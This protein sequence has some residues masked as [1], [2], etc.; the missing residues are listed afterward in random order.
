MNVSDL[1][2]PLTHLGSGSFGEISLVE[3]RKTKKEYAAKVEPNNEKSRL[4]HEY[5]IYRQLANVEGVPRVVDFLC[6]SSCHIMVMDLLGISLDVLMEKYK[7]FSHD[8]VAKLGVDMVSLMQNIHERGIIHRDIKPNNFMFDPDFTSLYIM[9]FGLSKRYVSDGKHMKLRV[10]RSLVGTARYTSLNIH[11]GFEPSRRDD[12]ESIGY[13]MV[14]FVR[15]KLPWQGIRVKNKDCKDC[16]KNACETHNRVKLIGESK[17]CISTEIL[18]HGMP[19]AFKQFIDYCRDL[20][21]DQVPDYE[22]LR[23][24]LYPHVGGDYSFFR[25]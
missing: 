8:L 11:H 13:M 23:S 24:L 25:N 5:G 22:Y 16:Q 4:K 20:K 1:Y 7:V 9:D 12:L 14:Y 10:D 6:T 3:C 21:F 15:G 17:M 18:C 19:I 2:Y